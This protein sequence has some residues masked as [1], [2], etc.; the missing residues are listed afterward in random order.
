MQKMY[1]L[2]LVLSFLSG[3]GKQSP[4]LAKNEL[5]KTA[6]MPI[7]RQFCAQIEGVECNLCAQDVVATIK[8]IQGVDCADFVLTNTDYEQGYVRFYYDVSSKNMDLRLLDEL[9]QKDGFE[10]ISLRGAFH[11]EPFSSDGK[12]YVA[13]SDD[14]AMP[15]CFSNNVEL[16]KKMINSRPEKLFA[17]GSIKKDPQE[18]AYFFTLLGQA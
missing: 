14:I 12:K 9:L 7:L 11:L 2:V 3:C 15:F 18:G 1:F 6:H 5:V 10:L 13:L 17:E 16:L 4:S 8:T